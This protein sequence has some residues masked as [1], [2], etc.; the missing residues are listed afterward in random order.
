MAPVFGPWSLRIDLWIIKPT[1]FLQLVIGRERLSIT[2][3]GHAGFAVLD[4]WRYD[5]GIFS[6]HTYFVNMLT[7]FLFPFCSP[8]ISCAEIKCQCAGIEADKAWCAIVL[9]IKRLIWYSYAMHVTLSPAVCPPCCLKLPSI[10]FFPPSPVLCSA[11]PA[12]PGIVRLWLTVNRT[13]MLWQRF[14]R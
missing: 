11:T 3:P 12:K 6:V 7:F 9:H 5:S 4:L 2:S 1:V 10:P 8:W 14:R 13:Q